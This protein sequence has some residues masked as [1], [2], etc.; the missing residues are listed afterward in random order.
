MVGARDTTNHQHSWARF[1]KTTQ[2][3]CAHTTACTSSNDICKQNPTTVL[4]H[5]FRH[6]RRGRQCQKT[7]EA[8]NRRTNGVRPGFRRTRHVGAVRLAAETTSPTQHRTM[9]RRMLTCCSAESQ[10]LWISVLEHTCR[11]CSNTWDHIHTHNS[12]TPR[13]TAS[14]EHAIQH[15]LTTWSFP[16]LSCACMLLEYPLWIKRWPCAVPGALW[17]VCAWLILHTCASCAAVHGTTC[18]TRTHP[19]TQHAHK[20]RRCTLAVHARS[21][22]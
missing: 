19:T 9:P 8:H 1:D 3:R 5:M 4:T 14:G 10:R 18:S 6:K 13:K 20:L 22:T 7:L 21:A 12:T 15:C 17:S 2:W 11:H 16:V